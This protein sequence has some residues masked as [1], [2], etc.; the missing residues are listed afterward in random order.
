MEVKKKADLKEDLQFIIKELTNSSSIK[1]YRVTV[2]SD[3]KGQLIHRTETLNGTLKFIL[4]KSEIMEGTVN[5][6]TPDRF[7][8]LN[9]KLEGDKIF[10]PKIRNVDNRGKDLE[11]EAGHYSEIPLNDILEIKIE[12]QPN[13][14]IEIIIRYE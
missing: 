1:D 10:F 3:D 8:I 14:Q 4:I 12:S 11:I 6:A 5:I 9:A 2:T 7:L 13:Q